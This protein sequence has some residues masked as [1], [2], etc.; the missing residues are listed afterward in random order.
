MTMMKST[1]PNQP[2]IMAVVPTPLFTLP[3]PRSWAIVLAATD[4]V[5]CHNTETSTNIE[6]TKMRASAICDTGRDGK[7]LTSLSDP[8]SS[9]SSCQPGKVARRTKHTKAKM[10]AMILEEWLV[11]TDGQVEEGTHIRYGNTILSLNVLATHI[12]FR[13]SRST[14]T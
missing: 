1:K 3:F 4:A 12:R 7:G 8:R 13:G 6:A 5:C 11:E 10:I 9:I 2:S 14:V